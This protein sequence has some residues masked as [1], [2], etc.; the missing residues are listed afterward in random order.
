MVV[1]DHWKHALGL[2]FDEIAD[3]FVRSYVP[4]PTADET[5]A[6]VLVFDEALYLGLVANIIEE[7]ET[8]ID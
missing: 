1:N 4:T 8:K 7:R 2:K 5:L 3:V 6:P